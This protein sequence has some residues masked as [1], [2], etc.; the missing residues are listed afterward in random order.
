MTKT[1]FSNGF[2]NVPT[3]KYYKYHGLV[4]ECNI[5]PIL[6]PYLE[7]PNYGKTR[8]YKL[9]MTTVAHVYNAMVD[10]N[11]NYAVGPGEI[12]Y[13]HEADY[14]KTYNVGQI[15]YN[16][17]HF[18]TKVTPLINVE[19]FNYLS[20]LCR[21]KAVQNYM[22]CDSWLTPP[23]CDPGK[24]V[25][26]YML[27]TGGTWPYLPYDERLALP[28]GITYTYGRDWLTNVKDGRSWWVSDLDKLGVIFYLRD[29]YPRWPAWY[30]QN[31]A[32]IYYLELRVNVTTK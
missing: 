21:V 17:E 31:W 13:D 12:F 7:F 20:V 3:Q 14:L 4:R 18:S 2:A 16:V 26:G 19:S 30:K 9:E 11:E 24:I 5:E 23:E 27:E 1:G 10:K 22:L 25:L 32:F 15:M 28:N 29:C 8:T 6:P